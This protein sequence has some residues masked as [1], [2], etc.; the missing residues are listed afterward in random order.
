MSDIAVL[1]ILLGVVA[2]IGLVAWVALKRGE[3]VLSVV[4]VLGFLSVAAGLGF[5]AMSFG[6]NGPLVVGVQLVGLAYVGLM[7]WRHWTH[8]SGHDY[9]PRSGRMGSPGFR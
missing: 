4:G 7:L 2:F 8:R 9:H 3:A 1:P 6:V 5:C